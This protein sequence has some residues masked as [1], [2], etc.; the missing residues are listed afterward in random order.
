MRK[1]KRSLLKTKVYGFN[2]WMDQV[3][4]IN[5]ILEATGQSSEAPILRE[6]IDEALAA[7]R[8]KA[9]QAEVPEP[10]PS[11]QTVGETLQTLQTLLLRLIGQEQKSLRAQGISLV[12]LQ[13]ILAE[14]H[15][16][17]KI[18][19]DT[20]V[21]PA[22]REKRMDVKEIERRLDEQTE[23]AKDY[24]YGVAEEIKKKQEPR[25]NGAQ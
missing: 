5:E 11:V 9:P 20:L 19:W 8:R 24:A 22:L 12:L 23:Q 16:G 10:P 13:E 1:T 4:A 6:L 17:R 14:A 15:A 2:P 21:V 3:T 25:K 7:R 18:S